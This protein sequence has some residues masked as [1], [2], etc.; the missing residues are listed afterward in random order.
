[1]STLDTEAHPVA[2]MWRR[3]PLTTGVGREVAVMAAGGPSED[4]EDRQ[5]RPSDCARASTL[6]SGVDN[7]Y[8]QRSRQKKSFV[9]VARAASICSPLQH[10]LSV[11]LED[12]RAPTPLPQLPPTP[13]PANLEL[14]V[15]SPM[16]QW[17][18]SSPPPRRVSPTPTFSRP[19]SPSLRHGYTRH[20]KLTEQSL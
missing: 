2:V 11:D 12:F 10:Q 20:E 8:G 17:K 6:S 7:S 4:K 1:M 19:G 13:P 5:M 16:F 18:L 3:Q 14:M 15:E 9:A